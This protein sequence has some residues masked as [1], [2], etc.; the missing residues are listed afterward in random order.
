LDAAILEIDRKIGKSAKLFSVTASGNYLYKS[1][2][3]NIHFPE[4]PLAPGIS[5]PGMEF[6]G[7]SYHN[8][9]ISAGIYQPIFTGGAL[10][11][12]VKISELSR[13]MNMSK[14]DVLGLMLRGRIK[15]VFFK[16]QLLS[17]ER[18][19]LEVLGEKMVNHLSRLE[20]LFREDL[21][22]KSQVLETRVKLG[23]IDLSRKAVESEMNITDHLFREL[24]GIP[25]EEVEKG[26]REIIEPLDKTMNIFLSSHPGLKT[27]SG[28]IEI[29][30]VQKKIARGRDLPQIGGF[31]EV[32][33]GLPGL[34][35]LGDEWDLYVQGGVTVKMN[36]F[37]WGRTGKENKITDYRIEKIRNAERDLVRKTGIKLTGLYESLENL[38]SRKNILAGMVRDASEEC[39]LKKMLYDEQQIS[40]MDYVDS[41]L[42]V[43][44]LN[45]SMGRIEFQAELV[46][47]EI[48]TL[49]GR[50]EGI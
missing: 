14:R 21:A 43:E 1:E 10:S 41:L 26:Y 49:S 12:A 31:A 9:D 45:A 50:R 39:E 23:E 22:G 18:K 38:E 42:N 40:N 16:Y 33:Y 19:S 3:I 32:H 5:F 35:F 30:G 13:T 17:S 2:K 48:N 25:V 6:S 24:T 27:L 46:K 29:L 4:M 36:L 28:Q 47:A 15:A 8:Y 44:N 20:D 7:G 37:N 11:G 34:N